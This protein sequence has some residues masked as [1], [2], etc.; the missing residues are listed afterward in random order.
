[1]VGR[2]VTQRNGGRFGSVGARRRDLGA[3]LGDLQAAKIERR[4]ADLG[5]RRSEDRVV[6]P[7]GVLVGPPIFVTGTVVM[8]S[9]GGI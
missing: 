9:E 5:D 6:E 4:Q 8:W 3:V 2:A 7:R 1:M